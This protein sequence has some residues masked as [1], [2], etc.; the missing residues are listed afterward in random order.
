LES[1]LVPAIQRY[2][3][4]N[5]TLEVAKA[6]VIV[7]K[8]LYRTEEE[9]RRLRLTGE[10]DLEIYQALTAGY[11]H[12]AEKIMSLAYKHKLAHEVSV[13]HKALRFSQETAGIYLQEYVR[14]LE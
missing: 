13:L 10:L 6:L 14:G 12:I 3:E 8:E 4:N 11:R 7:N 9:A 2:L 1:R 5:K